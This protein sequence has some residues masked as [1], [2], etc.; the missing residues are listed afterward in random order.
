[1]N[2]PMQRILFGSPG[3]G[4]SYKINTEYI[5]KLKI[6]IGSANHV[7]VVFHPEYTYG[8]F[9]GKLMPL[10]KLGK[11]ER[12]VEYNY[13]NG[14]FTKALGQAYKNIIAAHINYENAKKELW[15]KFKKENKGV[16]KKNISTDLQN[17]YGDLEKQIIKEKPDNVILIIDEINRGNS[18]SIF[19]TIF[20]LLDRDSTGWSSY[21]VTLSDLEYI[22]LEKEIGFEHEKK[23]DR[24]WYDDTTFEGQSISQ[25]RYEELLE[26]IMT[27]IDEISPL[28]EHKIKIPKNLHLVATMNTSD[29]SIYFMDNAFK[30]R[31][32]WEFVKPD[33][34]EKEWKKLKPAK[35]E[36][37]L[38]IYGDNHGYWFDFKK[39][40]NEFIRSQHAT[41]RKID[42]KQIGYFFIDEDEINEY[43]VKSKLL[44]FLWDSVFPNNKKPLIE[45][46]FGEGSLK[47]REKDLVSFGQFCSENNVKTF[48]D[49]IANQDFS[50]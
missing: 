42:D 43:H 4:K 18:A 10:S 44:F 38:V 16:T 40:L 37:K 23:Y 14:H 6:K 5:E 29:N 21:N 28:K 49:K 8:D 13:Y 48:V 19:G 30:R 1:M 24:K 46:L 35:R 9:I 45:L 17:K 12:K 7:P 20:Q 39:S 15:E 36:R 50:L 25:D 34:S 31:W 22:G 47:H 41:I 32:N 33:F 11:G 3:T 27:G 2:K 26:V